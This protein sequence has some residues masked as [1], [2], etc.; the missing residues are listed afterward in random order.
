MGGEGRRGCCTLIRPDRV[1]ISE[2]LLICKGGIIRNANKIVDCHSFFF[3]LPFI[4]N[5]VETCR[6]HLSKNE[7]N[8]VRIKKGL[9]LLNYLFIELFISACTNCRVVKRNPSYS[10]N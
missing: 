3:I 9:L 2:T 7:N 1:K 4:F 10:R 6:R 8:F 5:G